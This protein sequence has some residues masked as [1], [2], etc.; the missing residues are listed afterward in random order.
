MT[1]CDFYK[2]PII[3]MVRLLNTFKTAGHHPIMFKALG[4]FV[5]KCRW[6]CLF[7]PY[8][9]GG[10]LVYWSAKQCFEMGAIPL[11]KRNLALTLN[12]ILLIKKS[13]NDKL[14]RNPLTKIRQA[15]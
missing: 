3:L 6:K 10:Y 12:K 13:H 15:Y 14:F 9:H 7:H 2:S 5:V 1:V 4:N 11:Y 8:K